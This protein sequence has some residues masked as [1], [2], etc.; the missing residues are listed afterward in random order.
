MILTS[1][2]LAVAAIPE[3]LPAVITISLALAAKRMIKFNSLI[4]KLPAVETLGSVS[5]ICTDKTGTLTKNKMHVE[6]VFV[7]GE[8]YKR[9]DL[10]SDSQKNGEF[11]LLLHAFALNNDA[12][13]DK[14]N[15]IKGDST[16]VALL[17]VALEHRIK[18]D[19]WPRLAEIAFDSERKL[20]TTF[21]RYEN[22][23]ISL[24]KGAPDIILERCTNIETAAL[25]QKVDEMAYEGHRVLGFACRYWDELPENPDSAVHESGLQFIGLTGIIDPPREEVFEAVAQSKTAGIVPVMITGDHP[26]T[27]RTIAKRIGILEP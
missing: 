22:K 2:S 18:P 3:A 7:N 1:I 10:L 21:H 4:R 14:D 25:Q 12:A 23:I 19:A 24:T 6:R 20:M 8:F 15:H 9:K 11:N 26:I 27:A 16:E 13:P 17:E 5:Y